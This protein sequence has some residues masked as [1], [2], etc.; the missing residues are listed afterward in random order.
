LIPLLILQIVYFK[1]DGWKKDPGLRGTMETVCG[2][3]GCELTPL[4][5]L[6]S[7]KVLKRALMAKPKNG[8]SHLELIIENQASYSQPYPGLYLKLFDN[9]SNLLGEHIF[10]PEEYLNAENKNKLMPP[11]IPIH[12]AFDYKVEFENTPSYEIIFVE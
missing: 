4:R 10:R 7:I 1:W 9:S 2:I 6:N 12:I 3:F 5:D 8:H 11:N